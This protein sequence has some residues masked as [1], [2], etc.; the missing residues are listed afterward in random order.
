[1]TDPLL[2]R[3]V[4]A[5]GAQYLVDAEIGRGGMAVVYRATDVRLNRRVAIKLLPPELAFNAD[6]RERFLREAQTSAQLTHPH[7]VPIYTV[8]EREGMVYFVMALVDGES[9]AQRLAREPQLPIDDAR[10]IMADVADAL[11]YASSRGVVHRDV[12]PDNIMLERGTGRAVVTDFGIARAAAGD[13]R[14]TVTGVAVGTPAYMS[15][16]QALGERELDGRSDIYSLGVVGYQ[17]LAGRTPFRASNTPAM[18]VKHI[19]ETPHPVESLRP[20][21]PPALAQAVMRALAKKP[22]ERWSDAAEFRA[23][24]L[25][26]RASQSIRAPA[27]DER[28]ARSSQSVA[29]ESRQSPAPPAFYQSPFTGAAHAPPRPSRPVEAAASPELPAL[30]PMPPLPTYGSRADWREWRRLQRRW[31]EERRRRERMALQTRRR[32]DELDVG[33]PVEERVSSWRR[34]AFGGVTSIVGLATVNVLTSPHH[35]WF[36][37]P[38]VFIFL[39][40]IS[41]AGRLWADG[42]PL[43]KLFTR[44]TLQPEG[45]GPV[46]S[47]ALPAAQH[48]DAMA[49]RLAPAHVLSGPHGLTVRRA[50]E[51]RA[52]VE[53]TLGRLAPAEREMIPDVLPTVISLAERVG[54][55]ATTLHGLDADVN[56]TSVTSLDQRIASL[57][58]EAGDEPTAEQERRIALLER[59]RATIAELME[60]RGTLSGQLESA[61]LALHNLRLDLIK[62][63]SSG[64][65]SAMSDLTSATQEARAISREIGHAVDAVGEVRRL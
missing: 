25:E 29:D 53:E 28:P 11:S 64:L 22:E 24:I 35:M 61:S 42:V 1:M 21:V 47:A 63:R 8:D 51:D 18:L 41:H 23:A 6:V 59:Q 37:F 10:R 65:G 19:S 50:A 26:Q 20:D 38:G 43:S 13:S 46:A 33:R 56:A 2:D 49:R 30:P 31:D 36:V 27:A 60:R 40:V 44:G 54:S 52:S 15:P 62:L 45:Q 9:L 7:I 16:E 12:K 32:A 57:K 58:T 55:L 3:L 5:V 39:G 34:R 4:A 17:M 14:L 48:V